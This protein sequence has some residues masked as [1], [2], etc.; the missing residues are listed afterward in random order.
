[1]AV[2]NDSLGHYNSSADKDTPKVNNCSNPS[3]LISLLAKRGNKVHNNFLAYVQGR[4]QNTLLFP[5]FLLL[6]VIQNNFIF[7]SVISSHITFQLPQKTNN[8]II[9][10]SLFFIS[11]TRN[12]KFNHPVQLDRCPELND[13]ILYILSWSILVQYSHPQNCLKH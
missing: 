6:I 8:F 10:F 9:T 4:N 2:H 1:M 3:S 5:L 7:I 11:G 12:Q 13:E